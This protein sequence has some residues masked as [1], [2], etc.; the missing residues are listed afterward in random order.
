LMRFRQA[1]LTRICCHSERS[2][3]SLSSEPSKNRVPTSHIPRTAFGPTKTG[4]Q[5]F[6][7]RTPDSQF[8]N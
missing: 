6:F 4:S 5:K 1:E 8:R 7:N 2:E 3:E